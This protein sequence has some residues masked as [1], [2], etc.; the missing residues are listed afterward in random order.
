MYA[1]VFD[2]HTVSKG[3]FVR[4]CALWPLYMAKRGLR[5]SSF[6]FLFLMNSSHLN[7]G[8]AIFFIFSMKNE[9]FTWVGILMKAS[10]LALYFDEGFAVGF[11]F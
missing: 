7:K 1:M 9:S 4:D 6:S 3:T 11:V 10:Y 2:S 8:L 5:L